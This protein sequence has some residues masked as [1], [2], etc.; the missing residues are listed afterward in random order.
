MILKLD[1]ICDDPVIISSIHAK[2][3][4]GIIEENNK[5]SLHDIYKGENYKEVTS[6]FGNSYGMIGKFAL[7]LFHYHCKANYTAVF[8]NAS[9]DGNKLRQETTEQGRTSQ[10][11]HEQY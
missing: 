6:K 7:L 3:H 8:F 4:Y 9:Y 5:N 1:R 2:S 10:N 11:S